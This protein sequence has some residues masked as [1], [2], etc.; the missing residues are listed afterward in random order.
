LG[1]SR[2]S[3]ETGRQSEAHLRSILPRFA[4]TAQSSLASRLLGSVATLLGPEDSLENI[5]TDVL[6]DG[7]LCY[8]TAE[9]KHYE[10]H[11][12]SSAAP[13][14]PAIIEP[15]AGP[16]RWVPLAG[17]GSIVIPFPVG[18]IDATGI[19]D[20]YVV[21]ASSQIAIWGPVPTAFAITSFAHSPALVQV[22]AT[23]TTP[24]FTASYNQ[25]ATSASLTDTDGDNDALALPATSFVSPHSFT[26]VVFGQFVTWTLHA[27]SSLGSATASVTTTWG[28]NVYED[29][30]VDPGIYNAAFITSLT[31][32]LKTSAAGNYS[33]NSGAG[34]STFFCALTSL[35]L[36]IGN[37][38]VGGFPFACSK[39]ASAIPVT[40]TN[41]VTEN[42]DVFRSDNTGLGAYTLQVTG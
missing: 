10:L 34:T 35:G 2:S 5:I 18:D 26:K 4:M 14:P 25:A 12:D 22:G 20:G 9:H 33:I 1:R 41:G 27:A 17:G 16:G 42:F 7:C 29:A 37:F 13:S 23:L 6:D 36:T 21:Q 3:A 28:A 31:A 8:V 30:A 40:N 24:A 11:R 15:I 32:T 38:F 39:V 19:P